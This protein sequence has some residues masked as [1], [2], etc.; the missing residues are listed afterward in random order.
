MERLEQYATF[1]VPTD[2]IYFD[3]QFNC[4]HKF[5]PLSVQPLAEN[6]R[7]NGL[8][9]PVIV[10][11]MSDVPE[12]VPGYDFRMI[13]GHRRFVACTIFL[14]MLTIPATIMHG[15]SQREAEVLNLT[16][17][18]ERVDLNPLE[19]ALAIAKR[20]PDGCSLR[21]A[22]KELNRDTRWVSQRLKL[23]QLP[24]TLREKV[25]VGSL[26]L[27][28]VE[29]LAQID[30]LGAQIRAAERIM[31]ARQNK[32]GNQKLNLDPSLQRQFRN[33]LSKKAI[34]AW[35]ARLMEHDL[36]GLITRFGSLCAGYIT[37]EEFEADM[38]AEYAR[39][40][41]TVS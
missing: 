19:Q 21:E 28:D 2:R 41:A 4:R 37:D 30:E 22:A 25:A 18:L 6:I 10:Q 13:A 9:V 38:Q 26:T 31:E 17:N 1:A 14:K 29:V 8:R 15:L 36:D 5:T 16:E 39:K 7:A 33:R 32:E 3:E 34:N 20:F 40:N 23:L 24:E 11:P 35:V 12:P 27:L